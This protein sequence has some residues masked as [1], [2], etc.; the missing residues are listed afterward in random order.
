MV[1]RPGGELAKRPLHFIWICDTSASMSMDGKIQSLNNAIRETIPQMKLVANENPNAEVFV[2]TLRFSRDAQWVQNDSVPLESF[3]W[4]DLSADDLPRTAAFSAEFRGRLQ[5]EGAKS[6]DVQISLIWNNY[7]DLDLHVICPSGEE[8][9]FGHRN[10]C[11]GGELDVD[12]NVSPTSEE[13]VENIYWPPSGAPVGHYKVLVN[14]YKNH[15]RP[16]CIDPTSF[17]VAVSVG[18]I[19]QEFTGLI[20]TREKKLIH[21]FDLDESVMAKIGGGNT[22]MGMALQTV[23]EHLKIPPMT[24]RALPPILVLVSDGQPTD[25]FE[26]GLRL[27]MEQP[28]GKKAVRIA[29]GIGQDANLDIL[30]KFIGHLEIKPLLANNPESLVRYIKWASTAVLKAASSPMGQTGALSGG[31]SP[32]VAPL[33]P[34]FSSG[35]DVW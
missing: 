28:W 10:S 9:Y 23:A 29:I 32:I 21:E 5:R 7:N 16:G 12:M 8:I 34:E 19:V 17:K 25:D 24:E 18:G 31:H 14:H 6:G 26:S 22:D 15:H 11:C 35:T 30:Q 13:P 20:K 27:L 2:K 4:T 3:I 1:K 33:N